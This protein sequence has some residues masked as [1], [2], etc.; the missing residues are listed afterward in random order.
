MSTEF[1]TTPQRLIKS[2]LNANLPVFSTSVLDFPE[3]SVDFQEAAES[4]SQ[5]LSSADDSL[6]PLEQSLGIENSLLSMGF[7]NCPR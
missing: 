2:F 1:D 7:N 6:E 3:L 5:A 4:S